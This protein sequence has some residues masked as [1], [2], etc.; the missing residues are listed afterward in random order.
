M[1]AKEQKQISVAELKEIVGGTI[2]VNAGHMSV[3]RPLQ[4]ADVVDY[5]KLFPW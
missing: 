3:D 1:T 4:I 2:T 5:E